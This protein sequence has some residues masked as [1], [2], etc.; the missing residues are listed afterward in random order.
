MGI[1]YEPAAFAA[2]EAGMPRLKGW[3]IPAAPDAHNAR[4]TVLYL[5][6][7]AG[8]LG[9]SIQTLT[10]LHTLGL[11]ILAFDYRGYG[12]SQFAHP[13]EAHWHEDATW[14]LNYL[15]S[16]RHVPAASI[17]IDGKD[18]GANLALELAAAHSEL[19][20]VVIESPLPN[21]TEAIF[22][23][24]RARMVPAHLLVRD[25]FST[26]PFAATL[27]VPSLWFARSSAAGQ[28][29]GTPPPG[30]EQAKS[31]KTLVWLPSS[32]SSAQEFGQAYCRW[33]DQLPALQQA[34]R[35]K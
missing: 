5:H 33:L 28:I 3:W 14:A 32:G 19:A 9:D 1:A 10:A 34:H 7:Q 17:L 12:Q 18:L 35:A 21:P 29:A 20:G 26:G 30:Y 6:G 16:T 24:P 22:S 2:T 31:E 11:N 13:S 27:H 23:D 4:L 25:R 8:N 15:T